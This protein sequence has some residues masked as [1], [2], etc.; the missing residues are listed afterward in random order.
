[1]T[2]KHGKARRLHLGHFAFMRAMVQGVDVEKSWDR[3]L[4]I[5]GEYSDIRAVRK[6]IRWIRDEFAAAAKRSNLFGTA[7]LVVLDPSL[8]DDTSQEFPTLETFAAKVGMEDWSEEEQIAA[9]QE[10]YGSASR[11]LSRRA[12]IIAKQLTAIRLLEEIA[13]QAPAAGDPL[14]S[15][16]N[17]DLTNRLEAASIFTIRALINTINGKGKNWWRSIQAIGA[18]KAQRLEEWLGLHEQS[19]G[20]TI[21]AHV[22]V[23]RS[24]LAV[25]A[26][27]AIVPRSTSI[28]PIDKFIVPHELDGSEG[29]YRAPVGHCMLDARNDYDAILEWLQTRRPLGADKISAIKIKRGVD[30]DAKDG[31]LDWLN[32]LSHTQRAYLREAERFLLWAIIVR[33]K[34]LSSMNVADCTAYRGFIADP[35]PF[36]IWCGPKNVERW[37]VLWRPFTGALKAAGQRQAI[38]ILKSFYEFLV[39]EGYLVGNPWK[40]VTPPTEPNPK[41]V[42]SRSLT[43]QQWAFVL[44]EAE[45]LQHGSDAEKRLY[46]ALHL[47]YGTGVRLS[48]GIDSKVGDFE[49]VSY[50]PTDDDPES[51]EGYQLQVVGKGNKQRTVPVHDHTI[52]ALTSYLVS[53]GLN[54]KP[55]APENASASLFGRA[56]DV[57]IQAPF[58]PYAKVA[59]DPKQGISASTLY[60]QMKKFFKR[61]ASK[62]EASDPIASAKLKAASV[63]WLRHT[64]ATH[65]VEK[66]ME[67][68]I[69]Q[70]RLGH[71]TTTTTMIY[72]TTEDRRQMKALRKLL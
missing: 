5:E 14:A 49:F 21:G 34:P 8:L 26:L 18:G 51:I 63:H 66:G 30:P 71:V 17:P 43:Q 61:C 22:A 36:D 13:S 67:I 54:A 44:A 35:S 27:S 38:I 53:R 16:L 1:M 60:D 4:R 69:L 56:L 72:V 58:S 59:V 31:P 64:H 19:I 55:D 40:G 48:E 52:K 20:L 45:E 65:A 12:R 2:I 42:R 6:T 50:P 15:W 47:F 33:R 3:Y 39:S 9:Y 37:S 25:G 68:D 62:L 23:P 7:R 28:V 46:F 70:K 10:E 29:Q 24:K 32:Y 41:R 11:K 57:E